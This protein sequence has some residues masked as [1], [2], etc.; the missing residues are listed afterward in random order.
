ME[1]AR[2]YNYHENLEWDAA[3]C[4]IICWYCC[5]STDVTCKYFIKAALDYCLMSAVAIAVHKTKE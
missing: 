4:D 5:C 1:L 2:G 3:K